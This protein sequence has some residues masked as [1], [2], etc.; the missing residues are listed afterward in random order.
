[1]GPATSAKPFFISEGDI[2][3]IM[4]RMDA[5]G[6]EEISFS[7][8]FS[9]L[10]PYFIFGDL[11]PKPTPNML[12]QRAIKN[13]NKSH[14]TQR[15]TAN[16]LKN[17]AVSASAAQRRKPPYGQPNFWERNQRLLEESDIDEQEYLNIRGQTAYRDPSGE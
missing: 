11:R 15:K 1:M 16:M 8:Y 13:R 3:S 17:R 2:N 12:A 5:D 4:R 7:D 14:E 6:D 10:L 9:S